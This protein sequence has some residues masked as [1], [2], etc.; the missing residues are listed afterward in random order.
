MGGINLNEGN[1]MNNLKELCF[2]YIIGIAN[3][4]PGVSGGTFALILGILERLM[5][6]INSVS[7]SKVKELWDGIKSGELRDKIKFI[8]H[9]LKAND[10]YFLV[11]ILGGA[12]LATIT[13]AGVM[14]YCLENHFSATYGLFFGMIL[15]SVI[16]PYKLIKQKKWRHLILMVLGVYLVFVVNSASNPVQKIQKKSA[17]YQTQLSTNSNTATSRLSYNH[18]YSSSELL[19]IFFAGAIAISAMILPGLSG[20]LILLVLGRY[21]TIMTAVYSV[22]KF[23]FTLDELVLLTIFTLGLIIG[24]LL[25]ARVLEFIFKK[26]HDDTTAFLTGLV[27]G[28]LFA[29]WPFKVVETVQNIYVKVDGKIELLS[30][31]NVQTNVNC[32]PNSGWQLPL[33]TFLIGCTIMVFFIKKDTE[34]A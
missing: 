17:I 9:F 25:F 3:I 19:K 18:T 21:L 6:I 20:S 12:V 14:T 30:E 27:G 13:L 28:S 32:L 26:W 23:R 34:T 16:I 22:F 8:H 1:F 24:I 15:L 29:L 7:P 4:I 2:G 5:S 10:Y 33:I 11:R 31:K